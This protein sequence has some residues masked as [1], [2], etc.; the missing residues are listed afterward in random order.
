M[1]RMEE[2]DKT[3]TAWGIGEGVHEATGLKPMLTPEELVVRLKAKG[4]V[5]ERCSEEAAVRE[6]SN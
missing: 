1:A 5:L 2:T 4:V 6:L 3:Y